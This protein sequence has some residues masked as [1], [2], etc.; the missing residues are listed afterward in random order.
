MANPYSRNT[1]APP[2]GPPDYNNY[3]PSSVQ[4]LNVPYNRTN[5]PSVL[6]P[7]SGPSQQN[8]P[9][10]PYL[11]TDDVTRPYTDTPGYFDNNNPYPYGNTP[12]GSQK[13][14]QPLHPSA[15]YQDGYTKPNEAFPYVETNVNAPTPPLVPPKRRTLFSRLFNGEQ[16]FAFFCWTISIIQIGVFIGELIK[17]AI[18]MKTPI[19]IQPTFNPLIGPSSYVLPLRLF[20]IAGIDQ[21]GSQI[22]TLYACYSWNHRYHDKYMAMSE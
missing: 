1:N 12:T 17:N 5:V 18:V 13:P 9:Y 21:H 11:R 8:D 22:S 16:R 4:E 15:S 14:F 19:Q 3:R 20:L 7:S 2:D 6:T 10:N